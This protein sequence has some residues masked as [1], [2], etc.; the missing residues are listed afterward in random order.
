MKKTVTVDGNEACSYTSYIFTEVAGIYPITPSS[1]MAEHIDEWSQG[2]RLN[3]FD[4]TV[5]IVEMQSESGAAGMVHGSLVSGLLTST[6]TSSQGLLLMLPNMYKIAGEMLPLTMHVAARSLSTH[7]LSI[8]GDHQDIY[9]ARMTGFIMIASSS[10]QDA[11]YLS[12]VAHLSAIES[13]IPV[14][15]FFDGFR[16]SHEINKIKV[17]EKEDYIK[18]INWES[19]E[20]FRKKA[21]SPLSPNT[22]GTAQ[23]DD[24][25]F[26]ITEARNPYYDKVPDIVNRYMKKMNTRTR[27]DYKPFN[28]YGNRAA[29]KMIVA[30][31][32]VCE[33]IK[34]TIDILNKQGEKLGLMEVHLYRP[35]SAKYFLKEMPSTICKVAVLDRTK[36][37]GSIGE[38]LYLD[39]SSILCSKKIKVVG[40]RYGLSSK[41][42]TPAHIKA[43]FDSLDKPRHNFTIGIC[44]D[45]T[46][47]SLPVDSSFQIGGTDDFLFYGYGSDGMVTASKS[48]I[49]LVGDFTNQYVQGYFA[50]DSKKSGGVTVSHLRFSKKPIRKAYYVEHPRVV[51]VSKEGYIKEF[52]V[53]KGIKKEGIFLLNTS[54][55]EEEAYSML[56]DN[57]KMILESKKIRFYVIDAYNLARKVGL[58]IRISTIME[59]AILYLTNLLDYEFAKKQLGIFVQHKFAKKGEEVVNANLMAIEGAPHYIKEV[60]L[61]EDILLLEEEFPITDVTKALL[62]RRGNEL[63]VS[64]FS[65]IV[66]GIFSSPTSQLEKKG[67]S[68]IVPSYILDNCIQCNQC[69]LVCPHGVI[70][71]YLLTCDEY[72]KAP[73]YVKKGCKKALLKEGYYF[74]VAAS[75]LDCTG[76]GLCIQNC[77]GLKSSKALITEKLKIQLQNMEQKRFDYLNSNIQNKNVFPKDTI[78]GSQFQKTQF[79]FCGAC[80]GCGETPYIKLLTQILGEK[81]VIAN[82]TGCSSIY[83]GSVSSLPYNIPWASSLFEDNAEYGYGMLI[84]SKKMRNRIQK[85]LEKNMDNSNQLLFK[86]WIENQE[87]YDITKEIYNALDDHTIPKELLDIKDY[88]V[89]RDIWMIGGDGWAYDIGF[90]GIDH[91][92][93]SGENINILVLDSEVYSNTGGQASKSTGLGSIASFASNGKR[94][95][96]KDLARICMSYENVY[97]ASV[98]L[99]HNF[100]HTIKVFK[101]ASQYKGP[102]II[103]AYSPCISHG[104]KK[105]MHTSIEEEKLATMCGYFPT[106]RYHPD[107]DEFKLFSQS[108]NFDLY[109]TF[110]EG[111]TRYSHLKKIDKN[112]AQEL[113]EKNKQYSEKR[114]KYLKSLETKNK[115]DK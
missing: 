78:K 30:M 41:N 115:K 21:I 106:F 18:L 54:K 58:G 51:V 68:D 70:R 111:E 13:S 23:N 102:S 19:L 28:Y 27:L 64:S 86:K 45:V 35:F 61:K 100:L 83:G 11:A 1:P 57:M 63:P 80:A 110:L 4:D 32:S 95:V 52:D 10:V 82:A 31:G 104:I 66:D 71:P 65:N 79:E 36:E 97:V 12:A 107:L 44:D 7:A 91:V 89:Y 69:S 3:L 77:P 108:V 88:L 56:S 81:I 76:C 84:A 20:K 49:K 53:L 9:A 43:V 60:H 8:F 15:H 92:L 17:L 67:I 37:A 112:M 16:T 39:V 59:S 103:I 25:Y 55:T 2:G 26:Q 87:N 24:I 40:G 14:M 47:L 42:T 93:S 72:E 101:E 99:G 38:P 114:F 74:T 62:K 6:Y 34:E 33:T 96:K 98:S 46:H 73:D 50:Y 90:S 22:R 29:K 105:G 109:E 5:K 94:T 113:L 48:I 85:I 75:I